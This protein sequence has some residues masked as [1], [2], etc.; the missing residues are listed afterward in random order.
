MKR[1]LPNFTLPERSLAS[2]LVLGA[3]SG[4]SAGFQHHRSAME[5]LLRRLML[6]AEDLREYADYLRQ[7]K[8]D[9]RENVFDEEI[10]AKLLEG[11]FGSVGDQ[12]LVEVLLDIP[13]LVM[14]QDSFPESHG[15]SWDEYLEREYHRMVRAGE[16]EDR[17]S[18]EILAD[19]GLTPPL[20]VEADLG[21]IWPAA[22]V[23][24]ANHQADNEVANDWV[25]VNFYRSDDNEIELHGEA[26]RKYFGTEH[27]QL[28]ITVM[29][30]AVVDGRIVVR[31][32]LSTA[33]REQMGL[34]LLF[35]AHRTRVHVPAN[36]TQSTESRPFDAE[37][38]PIRP[39]VKLMI[40]FE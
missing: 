36:S 13:W 6:N 28:R 38:F 10:D 9:A 21:A 39:D 1:D 24:S 26:S 18:E 5:S 25:P 37:A 33:P 29:R 32:I 7:H 14:L 11:D 40:E 27:Q 12:Q 17:S 35:G 23:R 30:K 4:N 8:A 19:L 20:H 2:D 31:V 3:R 22:M 15:E 34:R 16:I